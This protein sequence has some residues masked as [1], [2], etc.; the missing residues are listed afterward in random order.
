MDK[1]FAGSALRVLIVEHFMT[2]SSPYSLILDTDMGADCDD[3]GALSVLHHLADAGEVRPLAVIYSSGR[4]PWGAGLCDAINHEHGRP[5]PLGAY[6]GDDV[7][8]RID[9]IGAEEISKD[10]ARYGHRVTHG[11]DVRDALEVYRSALAAEPDGS[12]KIVA[13]GHLKALYDLLQSKADEASPLSGRD[14]VSAKVAELVVMG[15]QFPASGETAEWNFGACDAQRWTGP[16]LRDWPTRMVFTGFEIGKQ[17]VT[18]NWLFNPEDM[19]AMARSY[20][21]YKAWQGW[22][23]PGNFSWDQT[24]VLYAVR[25]LEHEGQVYW[26]LG[27][28]GSIVVEADGKNGWRADESGRDYYLVEAMSGAQMAVLID[29]LMGKPASHN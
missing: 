25:G 18:G 26:T 11:D 28:R 29:G 24:A 21:A 6:K 23:I 2:F 10:V 8:E 15:G 20:R 12:V 16:V 14:L 9:K 27:P 19:S 17:V 22:D 13:I 3:T 5:L 1:I 7:G 4:T